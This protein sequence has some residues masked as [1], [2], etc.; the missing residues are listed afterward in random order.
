MTRIPVRIRLTLAFALVMAI[1]LSAVGLLVYLR[2]G[3]ALLASVDQTLR[4]L[5][6]EAAGHTQ[7]GHGLIDR[8]ATGGPVVAEILDARGRVVRSTRPG[9]PPLVSSHG[10][11][12]RGTFG[13]LSLGSPRGAWR[14]LATRTAGG[15][16]VVVVAR[17]LQ[18]REEALRRLLRELFIAGPLALLLASLAGYGVTWAALRPVEAMRR[19]AAAVTASE[20]GRLPVPAADDELS[21]LATTLNEMLD[22][23]Q[24]AFE[25]ERRFVAD[26]SHELRTPL[27]ML[28]AELELALRRRRT[29]AELEAALRSAAADTE[30]LSRLTEE[31]L[32]IARSDQGPLPLAREEC[33]VAELL[34]TVAARFERRAAEQGRELRVVDSDAIVEVDP[35]RV[36]QALSNLVDNALTYGDG[37]IELYAVERED[38]LELHVAD[39]G[40]G[41]PVDFVARA[42]D[43]FSR[44]DE[45]RGAGG[46]GLGLSIVALI[47]EA[48]GGAAGADNVASGGADAWFALPFAGA[49]KPAKALS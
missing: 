38:S 48:H 34:E 5:S 33:A 17:S 9:L 19:R 7:E 20:P 39:A 18:P 32:L 45:G 37:P 27:A 4:S 6:S 42:F 12:A 25:H 23:L 2:V 22:R 11:S 21:R 24:A 30:R 16:D 41:F 49:A 47:A 8:D 35:L 40:R 43:R 15:S 10:I 26:A 31:L 36:E 28:R 46:S 44:A 1:V 14:F 29:P 3:D 13:N